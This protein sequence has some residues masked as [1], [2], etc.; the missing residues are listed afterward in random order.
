MKRKLIT[1]TILAAM[2]AFGFAVSASAQDA[3]NAA[4]AAAD[5]PANAAAAG[6]KSKV[7]KA[8]TLGDM[9]RAGGMTM[10]PL[11]FCAKACLSLAIVNGMSIRSVKFANP[12]DIKELEKLLNNLDVDGA[13]AYCA[14]KASPLTNILGAGLARVNDKD[15]EW[16]SIQEAMEESSIE[17]MAAPYVMVNYLAL[18]AS[19]APMLGLFGT[20]TGMVKAFNT[21][22]AEGAGS[23][24]KLADNISEALITTATGMIVG[25]PAMFFF[26]YY[27]NA[28]G[29]VSSGISRILGDLMFIFK[30]AKKYGPQQLDEPA[31]AAPAAEK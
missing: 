7:V 4:P 10:Y 17:E 9:W 16:D 26:F 18:I 24:Q 14:K 12:A 15:L 31:E 8:K 25:I 21:I 19:I 20:V 1:L 23:A 5:A 2:S 28:Y 11:A 29:K 30:T 6:D 3:N 13:L 27:K 22:A